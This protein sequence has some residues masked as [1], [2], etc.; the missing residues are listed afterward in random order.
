MK[1][2]VKYI[3]ACTH[4]NSNVTDIHPLCKDHELYIYIMHILMYV[5]IVLLALT[6]HA[7]ATHGQ[8]LVGASIAR[9]SSWPLA[10]NGIET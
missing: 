10:E 8:P 3:D 1:I 4:M 2:I 7:S 5:Y 9:A 6:H